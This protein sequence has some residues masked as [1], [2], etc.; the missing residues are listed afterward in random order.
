MMSGA[1][2]RM[3]VL[4]A[5]SGEGK[6]RIVQEFYR[7]LALNQPLPHYWPSTLTDDDVDWK[8]VRKRLAVPEFTP[9]PD[10]TIPWI[11]WSISCQRRQDG[12]YA[13]A[14]VADQSRVMGPD[15]PDS[16]LTRHNLA[17]TLGKSGQLAEA[18]GECEVL[19]VCCFYT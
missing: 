1:G 14:L 3:D 16:I 8:S 4:S 12:S 17:A 18:I 5:P 2:P 10:A 19:W 11:Y 6:T 15:H 9:D 13:Q 7:S